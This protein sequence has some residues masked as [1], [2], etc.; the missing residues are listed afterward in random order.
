MPTPG[1]IG[2]EA[3]AL[4]TVRGVKARGSAL[5][6]RRTTMLAPTSYVEGWAHYAEEMALEQGFGDGEGLVGDLGGVEIE[7]L[8]DHS[9]KR[10]FRLNAGPIGRA[11]LGGQQLGDLRRATH[12]AAHDR[13][14]AALANH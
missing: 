11:E 7:V 13:R 9:F 6:V 2:I 8:T 1:A 3:S 10:E 4:M 14:G 5:E 12:H